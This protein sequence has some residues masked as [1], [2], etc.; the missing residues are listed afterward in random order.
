MTALLVICIFASSVNDTIAPVR[1]TRVSYSKQVW[2]NGLIF[3]G[4]AIGT[5]VF[6]RMGD[7]AYEE[8]QDSET[9]RSALENYDKAQLYDNIRNL[10]AVGA[11]VFLSRAVYYQIKNV[12]A[13]KSYSYTPV[14]EI[15]CTCHPKLVFGIQKDL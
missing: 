4:C 2:I 11:V 5:G 9:I 12:K 8:Y 1:P 7:S 15:E 14:I 6:Y 3:V 10:F 13:S